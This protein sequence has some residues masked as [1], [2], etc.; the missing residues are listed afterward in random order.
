MSNKLKKIMGLALA[1]NIISSVVPTTLSLSQ[2]QVYAS[3]SYVL[4]SLDISSINGSSLNLYDD[5]K[6]KSK[7]K[8]SDSDLDDTKTIYSKISSG[9]KGIEIDNVK[10][11]NGDVEIYVSG[12]KIE[13]N[14]EIKISNGSSKTITLKI[15]D[16]DGKEQNKYTLKVSRGDKDDDDDDDKDD[17]VY[18]SN[19]ILYY[20]WNDLDLDFKKKTK[21]YDIN[22]DKDVTFLRIEA[23]PED[24]DYK[25]RVNGESIDE[26]DDWQ[27]KVGI[28]EGKNE[29]KIVV[30]DED[31]EN[32]RTYTLNITRGSSKET[33]N[34]ST[35]TSNNN[36]TSA[37]KNI[38]WKYTNGKWQ[39]YGANGNLYKSSWV[40]DAKGKSY[41]LGSDGNMVTGWITLG[42]DQYYFDLVSGERKTGWICLGKTWYQLDSRGVL[43]K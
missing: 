10:A 16:K 37:T 31:E 21:T 15:V 18:L 42:G 38:G 17:D 7:D 12:K 28:K 14:D 35:T 1:F 6:C 30:K 26:E 4:T 24:D 11:S 34:S 33:T 19:I 5:K 13:S 41:Y 2:K 32:E 39:Y 3:E 9:K 29:I 8:I 43:V 22:V 40:T 23:E 25:V 27:T 36:S 20:N